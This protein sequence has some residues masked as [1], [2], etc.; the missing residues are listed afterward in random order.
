MNIKLMIVIAIIAIGVGVYGMNHRKIISPS[1]PKVEVKEKTIAVYVAKKQLQPGDS[2]TSQTISIE[3]WSETKARSQGITGAISIN[4]SLDPVAKVIIE[5]GTVISKSSF[6]I[7][8]DVDYIDFIINEGM[9][10]YPLQVESK[11]IIGGVIRTNSFVDIMA[12]AS[13]SQN[14]A[15]DRSIKSY[16]D[17]SLSPILT[18]IK[19][20]K[21]SE[22]KSGAKGKS[23]DEKSTLIL[24]VTPK[25]VATLTIAQRIAQLEIHQSVKG[26]TAKDLSANAGDVLES[27]HAIREF[28]AGSMT[29][30]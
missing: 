4:Y 10:P 5:P 21:I 7:A 17:V 9:T 19:V 16:K 23:A 3:N 11:S 29:V 26:A 25:Q 12:L 2:I 30:K 18:N 28:R 20:L 22:E 27:Y 14:L 15:N 8:T 6:A 13:G 24:E 1:T